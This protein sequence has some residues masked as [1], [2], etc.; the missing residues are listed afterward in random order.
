M[1]T[2]STGSHL[3]APLPLE[4]LGAP[5]PTALWSGPLSSQPAVARVYCMCMRSLRWNFCKKCM[6]LSI[7]C[8][9]AE[10]GSGNRVHSCKL[11][12]LCALQGEVHDVARISI[13]PVHPLVVFITPTVS[14]SKD[15][16]D[17]KQRVSPGSGFCASSQSRGS[18]LKGSRDERVV[19][20]RWRSCRC[21][22]LGT[23]FL[24][25]LNTDVALPHPSTPAVLAPSTFQSSL[26]KDTDAQTTTNQPLNQIKERKKILSD[27]GISP[28]TLLQP[29]CNR[30]YIFSL[31]LRHGICS[32][33]FF[34]FNRGDWAGLSLRLRTPGLH[35]PPLY[36]RPQRQDDDECRG[37]TRE[38]KRGENLW[39]RM[40]DNVGEWGRRWTIKGM[41]GNRQLARKSQIK[42]YVRGATQMWSVSLHFWYGSGACT[43]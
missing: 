17:V 1:E 32:D 8:S 15:D 23:L 12:V 2:S 10:G 20:W 22:P 19:E 31:S 33:I 6:T 24:F 18:G 26:Q 14:S 41:R 11:A 35:W 43:S 7:G 3:M 30:Q 16:K 42:P 25:C 28:S 21:S 27:S 4:T 29:L 9:K 38:L 13:L 37:I 5:P 34:L 40:D 36:T 39:G